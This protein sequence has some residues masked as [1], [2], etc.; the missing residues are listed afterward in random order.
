MNDIH[1]ALKKETAVIQLRKVPTAVHAR[2]KMMATN[3]GVSL[4]AYIT[5]LLILHATEDAVD[6]LAAKVK[7]GLTK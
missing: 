3:D 4:E 2:L 6:E 1:P 7:A 5:A